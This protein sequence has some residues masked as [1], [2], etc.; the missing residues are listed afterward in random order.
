MIYRSFGM[1]KTKI[2]SNNES[3]K[4][5][6]SARG[7]LRHIY[8]H[9]IDNVPT[10]L[11]LACIAS[12]SL[13]EVVLLGRSLSTLFEVDTDWQRPVWYYHEGNRAL[14]VGDWKIVAD[15][16]GPWGL[17]NLKEDRTESNNL[18]EGRPE[19]VLEMEGQW[20]QMLNEIREVALVKSKAQ[21]EVS[22]TTENL[23]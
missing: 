17:F 5:S 15:K 14:R 2:F 13:R 12:D 6:N 7:E 10:I 18:A 19:Q 1:L 3:N 22:V 16:D 21:D 11:D 8:G 23:E 20:E 4:D 9:V